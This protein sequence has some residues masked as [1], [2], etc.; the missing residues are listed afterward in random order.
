[1]RDLGLFSFGMALVAAVIAAIDVVVIHL[2]FADRL[3]TVRKLA[4]IEAIFGKRLVRA[5][6]RMDFV[7]AG[8]LG[9]FVHVVF[10]HMAS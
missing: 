7:F 4:E 8:R 5:I 9:F 2:G 6:A 10:G 1:M 3:A